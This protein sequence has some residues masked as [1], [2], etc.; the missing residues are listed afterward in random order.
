MGKVMQVW[1]A[2]QDLSQEQE[3]L[4]E[5]AIFVQYSVSMNRDTVASLRLGR[6][7]KLW[8]RVNSK[9]PSWPHRPSRTT[10]STFAVLIRC[11][12]FE[13]QINWF[14]SVALRLRFGYCDSK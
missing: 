13:R 3:C 12:A 4:D 14:S 11:I 8:V 9:T 1:P 6:S 10:P 2:T 7:F 5:N